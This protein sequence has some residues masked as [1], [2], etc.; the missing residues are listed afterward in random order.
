MNIN[1]WITEARPHAW[2]IQ[3]G[4]PSLDAI[5]A[6]MQLHVSQFDRTY[7]ADGEP[8]VYC[9]HCNVTYPCPTVQVMETAIKENGI[10]E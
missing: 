4:H 7:D 5:D 8:G 2:A 3:S 10:T 6:V 1:K 9:D